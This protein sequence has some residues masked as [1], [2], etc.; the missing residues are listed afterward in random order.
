MVRLD[1]LN[2]VKFFEWVDQVE[3]SQIGWVMPVCCWVKFFEWVDQVGWDE[4][5]W[6]SN[7]L[8]KL[9]FELDWMG[10]AA[11]LSS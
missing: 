2:W 8:I 5:D 4:L 10:Y 3:M 1:G 6:D 7:E 11:V 9:L